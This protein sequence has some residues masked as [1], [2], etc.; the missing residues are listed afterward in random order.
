MGVCSWGMLT[1]LLSSTEGLRPLG[2]AH[3]LYHPPQSPG[4]LAFRFLTLDLHMGCPLHHL[5]SLPSPETGY[6]TDLQFERQKWRKHAVAAV[7]WPQGPT[8]R[9]SPPRGGRSRGP[10]HC[11]RATGRGGGGGV[12]WDGPWLPTSDQCPGSAQAQRPPRASRKVRG[13]PTAACSLQGLTGSSFRSV[14]R[15]AHTFE[16]QALVPA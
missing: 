7:S 14:K 12:P 11:L 10:R 8:L 9:D 2:P 16:P 1:L 13:P 6:P 5:R 15:C 3:G 4:H